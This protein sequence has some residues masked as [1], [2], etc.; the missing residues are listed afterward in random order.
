MTI[1]EAI[2]AVDSL[3]PNQYNTEDKIRWLA[4]LDQNIQNSVIDYHCDGK[5]PVRVPTGWIYA[6]R[7]YPVYD[8]PGE[9]AETK[10]PLNYT[11]ENLDDQLIAPFPYDEMYVYY[12]EMKI[13]YENGET[14]R[15]NNDAAMYNTHYN[16]FV[17]AYNKEHVPL[18]RQ[19]K[20]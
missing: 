8:E 5:K 20:L 11:E 4:V 13:D 15:Y 19:F 14:T 6:D 9:E 3:R 2:D 7:L 1:R 12:L 16:N 17:K 10:E 18:H